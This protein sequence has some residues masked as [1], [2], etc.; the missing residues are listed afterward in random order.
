MRK[1][2]LILLSRFLFMIFTFMSFTVQAQQDI[3]GK[4]VD[5]KGNP[6][7]GVNVLVKGTVKGT[8]TDHDG[9]FVLKNVEKGSVLV[10]SSMGYTKQEVISQDGMS[11]SMKVDANSLKEVIVTAENRAVS[12]QRVPISMDLVSGVELRE[13]G[14]T[15][16]LQL[17]NL[18]PSLGINQNTL[19]TQVFV[20]GV[21]SD[22]GGSE[23]QDQ[24]VTISVDGEFLNRPVALNASLYDLERI[25]VLKGPQGT[26][27]GRNATAGAVNIIAA[28]PKLNSTEGNVS[29]QYGNYNSLKVNA[30]VNLPLGDIAAVRVAAMS[31]THDGYR[32]SN[33][34]AEAG[35]YKG[36]LDNGNVWGA[37]LGLM[38]KP[39]DK[40]YAYVAGELNKTDQHAVAQYGVAVGSTGMPPY[41]FKTD[42][43]DD[44][45]VATPG[46]IKI[47]QTALRG[48]V[49]YDFGPFEFTYTGGYRK[50]DLDGYQPLNGFVPET[51][52]FSNKLKYDTQSHEFRLNGES[53]NFIWQAGFFYGNED[54]KA[55][56]G[57]FLPGAAGRFG[58]KFPYLNYFDL[59]VNSKTT[60]IFGQATI[61]F[62]DT[63]SFTGGLR[64]TYDKK[65]LDGYNL[66]RAPFGPPGTPAYFYP[67]SPPMPGDNG[68]GK[69][70]AAGSGSW[71]QITWLANL[72]Y[73]PSAENLWFAKASTGYKSG[74]FNIAEEYDAENLLAF[75]VGTKNYLSNRTLRLNGS[76]F[77]YKYSDQ[78]VNV[79]INETLGALTQNAGE[80]NYFGLELE[81]DWKATP[82]D[83]F[84]FTV[85]YL[86]GKFND[87]PTLVNVSG[88]APQ[89]VNLKGN[90]PAQSP[91]WILIG[92]YNH[93]FSLGSGTLDTRINSMFKSEYYLQAFNFT[94]DKQESFTKT[95]LNVTYKT[96]DGKWELGAFVNNLEDNRV[97]TFASFTGSNINIYN[98]SF[99]SPR[100]I[101]LRSSFNF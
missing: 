26:L 48:R 79:Y 69:V 76:A 47:N 80:S 93:T 58:G 87:L 2:Q 34:D 11:I 12:A 70:P 46:F 9:K 15:D 35:G 21:G 84:N 78:Q 45:D 82:K 16:L 81:G 3:N 90:V 5:E 98:W 4:V 23:L 100:I 54:Q 31:D 28:K 60:G 27:Y 61:N 95:D 32:E 91:K 37:R 75:E 7:P 19:F 71:N 101:G 52:S 25:E 53:T 66:Q 74:G 96:G 22:V 40:F 59:D 30:A 49:G 10:I 68:V 55:I 86:K 94:M 65:S 44:F 56:R 17:Q 73:K 38:L 67:D 97:I 20:R 8:I 1:Q 39:S 18:A 77:Y 29:A 42:L 92:G 50:V 63:W 72:E 43:P 6:F 83:Q 57:L 13:Q 14:I 51:F 24:A 88:G 36:D 62:T 89:P 33:G 85:N 64:Y 99:G 41:D